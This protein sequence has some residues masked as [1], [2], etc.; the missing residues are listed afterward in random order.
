MIGDTQVPATTPTEFDHD[1]IMSAQRSTMRALAITQVI[2]GGAVTASVAIGTL[3]AEDLLGAATWAGLSGGSFTIGTALGAQVL[4]RLSQT[5][6]RRRSLVTGLIVGAIGALVAT[7]GADQRMAWLYFLGLGGAGF[8]NSAGLQARYAATDL[9][10]PEQRARS[11]GLIVWALTIGAVAGPHLVGPM[12]P[13]A[14]SIG[15]P[16]L[17]GP[18]VAAAVL[19]ALAAV[20][21]SVLLRPD[22]LLFARERGLLVVQAPDSSATT[23]KRRSALA[24]IR[25]S[26]LAMLAVFGLAISQ[27]TMVAVMSMTPIHLRDGLASDELIGGVISLHILGM[28]IGSPIWGWVADRIGR[29]RTLLGGAVVLV[30]ACA[31]AASAEPHDHETLTFALFL[32]GVGWSIGLVSSSSLLTESVEADDRVAVQGFA[33]STT[34]LCGGI[35]A[36]ASGQIVG[37]FGYNNLSFVSFVLAAVLTAVAVPAA[38]RTRRPSSVQ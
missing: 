23:N 28:Y 8:A 9:A 24:A 26:K 20:A 12:K 35:A 14:K 15:I 4:A 22:P 27:A 6:G 5:A 13:V 32:L 11:V 31:L 3:L 34:S 33:D 7:V 29:T 37:S 36:L 17:A 1:D 38:L 10:K 2:I 21:A 19:A 30:A 18:L 16:P 25:E